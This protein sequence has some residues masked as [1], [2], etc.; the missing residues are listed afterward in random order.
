MYSIELILDDRFTALPAPAQV[1]YLRLMANAD[2]DGFV[3]KVRMIIPRKT[4]LRPLI[5]GGYIH[6]FESG[7]IVIMHW[8]QHN[9]IRSSLFKPTLFQQERSQLSLD[10]KGLY[11]FS[12]E[13]NC[14]E[15]AQ[16]DSIDK[17]S[18]AKDSIDQHSATQAAESSE[19]KTKNFEIFWDSFPK[20]EGKDTA[21][22][23][24]MTLEV[25]FTQ[26]MEGLENQKRSYRWTGENGK[27][28]PNP[29][30]WLRE[31]RWEDR[32]PAPPPRGV[33]GEMGPEE[34]ASIQRLLSL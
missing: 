15:T 17:N 30:R 23:L 13:K 5:E 24:F 10:N 21:R 19:T 7:V 4:S 29:T 27:Y 14:A 26:I 6:I 1:A 12:D 20:K 28:I 31:K 32:L 2:D 16:Q 11:I 9:K 34:I 33:Y 8:H 22:E 3:N 18:I 25:P